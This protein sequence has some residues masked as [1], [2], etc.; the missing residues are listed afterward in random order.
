VREG[1][2]FPARLTA[3]A[4]DSYSGRDYNKRRANSPVTS[5]SIIVIISCPSEVIVRF[6]SLAL[7]ILFVPNMVR[8]A[9]PLMAEP[10]SQVMPPGIQQSAPEDEGRAKLEKDMA[11]KA[12]QERQAD[13]RRDTEKL[14]KL[15]TELKESVDKTSEST[16]SLSVIKKAEEIEKLR[17]A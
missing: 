17:T 15:A 14:L 2:S 5:Q 6:K 8:P 10:S 4:Y 12:N 9:V 13:L 11:K 3:T 16:L 7:V 1:S